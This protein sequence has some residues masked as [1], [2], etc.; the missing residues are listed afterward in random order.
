MA[1][2]ILAIVPFFPMPQNGGDPLRRLLVL[3]SLRERSDLV[4]LALRRTETT[5]EDVQALRAALPGSDVRAYALDRVGLPTA[6]GRIRRTVTGLARLEPP[7]AAGQ[8]SA[9]L[10]AD[11][12]RLSAESDLVVLVGEGAGVYAKHVA[13]VPYVWDKSNVLSASEWDAVLNGGTLGDRVRALLTLPVSHVFE[14]RV[15]RSAAAS[16]VTSPEEAD[17]VRR[18][19]GRQ[20]VELVAS[21]VR[22]PPDFAERNMAMPYDGGPVTAVWL[23]SLGYQPNWSGLQR[24]VVAARPLLAS[25]AL[26]L[27]VAGSG[28]A[29]RHRRWLSAFP[30][31]SY[32]GYVEDL[33]AVLTSAHCGVVPVWSG[34]GIKMKTLTMIAYG[35]PI[36]ATPVALEGLPAAAAAYVAEQPADFVSALTHLDRSRL[37][38]AAADAAGLVRETFSDTAFQRAVDQA[39]RAVRG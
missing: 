24:L 36:I 4:V 38:T 17:R 5:E 35:I 39:L 22:L 2:R 27:I 13:P 32:R 34:A 15:L 1:V 37:D 6:Q 25:G 11:A 10:A 33:Q 21:A 18:R 19:H 3:Q 20:R 30:N 26:H 16:W 12:E 29:E 9:A 7:W 8:W 31:I 14:R 23:S 28:A